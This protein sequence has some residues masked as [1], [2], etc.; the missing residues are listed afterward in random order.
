MGPAIEGSGGDRHTY[1]A[2]KVGLGFD[3]SES[4]FLPLLLSWN[5]SC[6][7]PWD[8]RQLERK[9]SSAYRHSTKERGSLL[10]EKRGEHDPS[11]PR[12]S[13][14]MNYPPPHHVSW[15]WNDCQPATRDESVAGWLRERGI[16]YEKLGPDPSIVVRAIRRQ[17]PGH[18]RPTD[19]LEE[20]QRPN[21]FYWPRWA[22]C[23]APPNAR[24]WYATRYRAIIPLFNAWGQLAS[25]KARAVADGIGPKSLPPAE[26]DVARLFMANPVLAYTLHLGE[27]PSHVPP[28]ARVIYAGEGEPDFLS[29]V[30]GVHS[31]RR[32]LAGVLG[33]FQGSFSFELFRR[34]PAGSRL[35]MWHQQDD[36]GRKFL[37]DIKEKFAP[38]L[39]ERN[40][41][42]HEPRRR[43]HG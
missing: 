42:L 39:Q 33:Y 11:P 27:W 7:P 25:V 1:S 3:L 20:S 24:P 31:S 34:L 26:H 5:R 6:Q 18:L 43:D 13:R 28:D 15:L 14:P 4:E 32:P 12:R 8:E 23:G 35:V 41:E 10:Q 17:P 22:W 21:C 36:A 16:D 9:L 29:L 2:C 37:A 38:V 40:I 30:Q 19:E